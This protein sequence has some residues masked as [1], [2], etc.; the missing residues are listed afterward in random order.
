MG[1]ANDLLTCRRESRVSTTSELPEPI[2]DSGH[3]SRN[4]TENFL[5]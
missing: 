3:G 1:V 2:L 5:Q 4:P